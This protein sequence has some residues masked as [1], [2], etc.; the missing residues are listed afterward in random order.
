MDVIAFFDSI[1]LEDVERFFKEYRALGPLPGILL[2][3]LEA[4]FPFLPLILFV[5]ANANSFGLWFGFLYSWI[6]SS[7]GALL[8]F[9]LVRKF[10]RKRFLN[11]LSRHEKVRRMMNWVERHGFAPLFLMLCFPFTPSALVN[12][13]AGLSKINVWQF[14]LAV[15]S[16]K[17]VMIFMLSLSGYD[18]RELIE[19][20]VRLIIVFVVMALM[21]FIG[22]RIE[23]RLNVSLIKRKDKK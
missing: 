2:P 18:L 10:G 12:V 23:Q 5:I 16:G 3:M 14:A 19:E 17:L 20:P 7:A 21:W 11:F 13:V 4:F 15:L 6:G 1:T 8:V 22:K 9:F